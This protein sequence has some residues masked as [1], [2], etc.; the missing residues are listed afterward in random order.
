MTQELPI[1]VAEVG[2]NHQGSVETAIETI[3]MVYAAT[4]PYPRSKVFI[5][6]QKRNPELAVPEHM[7]HTPRKSLKTGEWT[8]YITYKHEVEFD[9][10]DYIEIDDYIRSYYT[11]GKP[12]WFVSV[13]DLDSVKWVKE[14][15][16]D[17]PYVKIPSAHLTNH[18]LIDAA[19]YLDIPMIL[20]TGMSFNYE[21]RDA[22]EI[23]KKN[24][25]PLNR[26]T[27]MHCN[28][29]YPCADDEIDLNATQELYR[30]LW[31]VFS[32]DGDIGFSSHSPSPY[33][34]I[35]SNFF[36]V[37]MIE[38]HVTLDRAMEGSDHSA[39][40]ERGAIKLLA[41]E[42]ARIPVVRGSNELRMYASEES[43]RKSLRGE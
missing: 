3:D 12:N 28:S 7:R 24:H 41:R 39:S 15:F 19:T 18:K 26:L 4:S 10:Y 40:L 6:F 5:K 30:I 2:I 25:S 31:D 17:M 43:K 22:L 20:S 36:N 9:L 21:I 14:N 37:S 38:F 1:L 33:P 27:V 35:Y 13:W 23:V 42:T 16:P 11:Y 8:D 34:A 29:S 32:L